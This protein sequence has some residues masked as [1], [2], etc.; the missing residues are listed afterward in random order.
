MTGA[1]CKAG[2]ASP[3]VPGL[4][5]DDWPVDNPKGQPLERVREIRQ[6]VKERVEELI[7]REGL[8]VRP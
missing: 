4:R 5:T 2:E 3:E 1:S 8:P 7:R 6:E